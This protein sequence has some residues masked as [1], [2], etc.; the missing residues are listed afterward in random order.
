MVKRHTQIKNES[1]VSWSNY[2]ADH[3]MPHAKGGKTILEKNRLTS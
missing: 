3:V 1:K 2:Q